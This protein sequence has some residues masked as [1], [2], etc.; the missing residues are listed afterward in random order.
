MKFI[1]LKY[2]LYMIFVAFGGGG[3]VL[4][5]IFL[6]KSSFPHLF[7]QILFL[8]G[9]VTCVIG[10]FIGGALIFV[11]FV[12]RIMKFIKHLFGTMKY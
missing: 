7:G 6:L 5:S 8:I 4:L 9:Y 2:A 11:I 12:S 10:I 1:S 3:L